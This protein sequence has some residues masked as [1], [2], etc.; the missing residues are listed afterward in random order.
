[1]VHSL[2]IGRRRQPCVQP[3]AAAAAP[4]AGLLTAALTAHSQPAPRPTRADPLD[5]QAS[6]PTLSYRSSFT[7]YRGL[8]DSKPIS[9]REANDIVARIGGWRVYARE[10]QQLDPASQPK[11]ASPKPATPVA[12]SAGSNETAKPMPAGHGGHKTP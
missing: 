3:A 5:L 4:L 7:Q 6:V 8:D 10:A 2:S 9:W 11:P 12:P 1:M